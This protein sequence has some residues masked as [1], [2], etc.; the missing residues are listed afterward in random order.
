[1]A[2]IG[3]NSNPRLIWPISAEKN[4]DKSDKFGL[5]NLK[6]KI[7]YSKFFIKKVYKSVGGMFTKNC[8]KENNVKI[9]ILVKNSLCHDKTN[10]FFMIY[11]TYRM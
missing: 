2:V 3:G 6:S 8:E 5:I 10:Q 7:N 9:L 11:L 4:M 1:M